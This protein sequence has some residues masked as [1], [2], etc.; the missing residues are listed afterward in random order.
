VWVFFPK[1]R[2]QGSLVG[3]F[4]FFVEN[5]KIL[6]IKELWVSLISPNAFLK[7]M[8]GFHEIKFRDQESFVGFC[9]FEN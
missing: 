2:D 6:R 8:D 5:L 1:F 4:F 9:F 3:G 7:I